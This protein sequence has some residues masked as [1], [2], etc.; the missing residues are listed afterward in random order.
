MLTLL[1]FTEK[2]NSGLP[3]EGQV[4]TDNQNLNL[5]VS[6]VRDVALSVFLKRQKRYQ[7]GLKKKQIFQ[8]E[9]CLNEHNQFDSVELPELKEKKIMNK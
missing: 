1:E 5:A 9:Y 6:E 2:N 7:L 4:T 8:L 3:C